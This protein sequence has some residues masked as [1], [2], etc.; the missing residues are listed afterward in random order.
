[1]RSTISVV[2][3]GAVGMKSEATK[4]LVKIQKVRNKKAN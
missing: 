1:M 3:K 2:D 4:T